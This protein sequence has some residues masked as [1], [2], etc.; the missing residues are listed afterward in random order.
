MKI[1]FLCSR[2]NKPQYGLCLSVY[3]ICPCKCYSV[4]SPSN[5]M[6]TF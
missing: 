3:G 4:S 6:P 5:F 2:L 1:A